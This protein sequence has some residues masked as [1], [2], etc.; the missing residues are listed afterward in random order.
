MLSHINVGTGT[1]VT[2]KE[3]AEN[4]MNV[5][6]FV[7][8]LVFDNSKPDGTMRK[9][10]DVEK[11]GSLGYVAPTSLRS[12]LELAYADFLENASSLRM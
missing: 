3:L 10:M 12:G 7:G 2:I 9:L 1:D 5:V 6:G 4:I 8:K 11:L